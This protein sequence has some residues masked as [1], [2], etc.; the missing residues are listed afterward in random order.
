MSAKR[1]AI[2]GSTGSIGR[3]ALAV[4]AEQAGLSVCALAAGNNVEALAG[5]IERFAPSFAA[6]AD[7]RKGQDL[8]GRFPGVHVFSG[9]GAMTDLVRA[10]RPDMLLTAVVGSA[11][12]APTL[13]GIDCHADLAI[14]NKETLVMAGAVVMAAARAAGVALLPVDSEHSAIFQCLASGRRGEVRRV[15]ITGSGGALRDHDDQAAHDASVDD[16]LAHPTWDM[17]RKIT[18]DSATMINKALEIVEAHWLFDLPADKI[19]VVMH[20]ESIVH[21]CVE[22]QDGSVLAQMSRPDMG[23][24]IAYALSYPNRPPRRFAPLDLAAMGKLTFRPLT[25]RYA[26]AVELGYEAIRRGGLAGAVLNAANEAAVE[27]FLGGR[28]ALGRIVP[29]VEEL[30]NQTPAGVEVNL[31]TLTEADAW[32]RRQ[33]NDRLAGPARRL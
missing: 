9:P 30:M 26:R 25:G 21:S 2:L 28:I 20:P 8:A 13:A 32:A 14:A 31:D 5:Q 16:A 29:L 24:P 10:S 17:G 19:D 27:A 4:I 33:V 18:I 23:M 11:G 1:I 15:I 3:Q 12:L 7:P 6:V 22:F